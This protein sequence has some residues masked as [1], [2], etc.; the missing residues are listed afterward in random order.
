MKTLTIFLLS[1]TLVLTMVTG[2]PAPIAPQNSDSSGDSQARKYIY[3]TDAAFVAAGRK[4]VLILKND[5]TLWAVGNNQFGQLADSKTTDQLIPV[6]VM[7]DIASVE[8]G[9]FYT[10]IVKSDGDSLWAVGANDRG[11]LGDGS[12]TNRLTPVE[13]VL[14][15]ESGLPSPVMTGVKQ[16]SASDRHTMILKKNNSLW[17]TGDNIEGQLGDSDGY[18][19]LK[20][21][22]ERE[23]LQSSGSDNPTVNPYGIMVNQEIKQVST[24]AGGHTMVITTD[25]SLWGFG[26]NS[27]TQLGN[28]ALLSNSDPEEILIQGAAINNADYVSAAYGYTMLLKDDETVHFVGAIA[29]SD[30][31][32]SLVS[33]FEWKEILTEVRQ[34][35]AADS[36]TMFVTT[37]NSLWAMGLNDKGQLGDGTTTDQTAPKEIMGGVKSV[38]AGYKYTYFIKTN[39]SLWAVG[40]NDKGQLG[41]GTTNNRLTPVQVQMNPK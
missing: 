30:G 24:G 32:D 9:D 10:M 33:S 12:T 16:V 35:S 37:N 8:A 41:D 40:A 23:E 36:H 34:V 31:Y 21:N 15:P 19:K 17:A 27:N 4:H 1:A 5:K 26:A 14:A 11:Q 20:D 28:N 3:F 18:Y 13:V 29:N 7:D 38:Y 2:C 6:K 39:G 25:D 22:G